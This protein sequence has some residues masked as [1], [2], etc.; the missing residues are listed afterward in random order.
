METGIGIWIFGQVFPKSERMEKRHV[1]GEW[2]LFAIMTACAYSFPNTFC[3]IANERNYIR[4]LIIVHLIILLV[5]VITRLHRKQKE[6]K[7]SA[8]V[9]GILFGG[10]VVCV[11]AQF[12][13]SYH[14]F[15]MAK[16]GYVY[17]VLFLWAF[18]QCSFIQAYL[19]EF[20]YCTNLG[21][22][23]T[24]YITYVGT[25]TQ[26]SFEEFFEWPRHH[27]YIEVIFL[28]LTYCIILVINKYCPLKKFLPKLLNQNKLSL[29]IFT[30]IEWRVFYVVIDFGLGKVKEENLISS[31][32]AAM[33]IIFVLALLYVKSMMK[34]STA[35]KNFFYMQNQ[36]M[37]RQ[38]HELNI[39]YEKYRC[40]VHDEKNMLLYLQECLSQNEV[41]KAKQFLDDYQGKLNGNGKRT[42]TGIST[43]DF[44]LNI[45]KHQMDA[46]AIDFSLDCQIEKIM[47]KDTDFVAMLGNLLD[48]AIEASVKCLKGQRKIYLVLK[49][50][51]DMF[52]LKLRNSCAAKPIQKNF[53]FLTNKKSKEDHGWGIES[54][55]YI[56][57]K[58]NG[59]VS[60][61]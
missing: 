2:L 51:N 8:I 49:N 50:V 29:F 48:N 28:L 27:T 4:N 53:K 10:I 38:Y 43:L 31:L 40:V 45:K 19:W 54:I 23:K 11:T 60:F 46:K 41:E 52:Y 9:Q 26:S 5:Y 14:S 56:T 32:V 35:E 3:G 18:Y 33:V 21:I 59:N 7:E 34:M 47:I 24:L 15:S 22:I 30:F 13:G 57:E 6:P 39:A 58:Y 20:A 12:W 1:F 16:A 36:A 37:E 42:W 55:K 44:L 61:Q 17:P 25:F